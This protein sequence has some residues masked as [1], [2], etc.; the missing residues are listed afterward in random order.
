MIFQ[1][2]A[3]IHLNIT[4]KRIRDEFK[5]IPNNFYNTSILVNPNIFVKH[6]IKIIF[7]CKTLC[8]TFPMVAIQYNHAKEETA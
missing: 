2:F 1:P 6:F 7:N 5:N 3:T 8:Y 4:Y